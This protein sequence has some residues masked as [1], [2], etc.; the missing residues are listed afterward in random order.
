MAR[1]SIVKNYGHFK[2][3]FDII[4]NSIKISQDTKIYITHIKFNIR[5]VNEYLNDRIKKV[6]EQ[7]KIKGGEILYSTTNSRIKGDENKLISIFGDTIIKDCVYNRCENF[8]KLDKCI[9][10]L[11]C[12]LIENDNIRDNLLVKVKRIDKPKKPNMSSEDFFDILKS[13]E[14]YLEQRKKL[15]E[16][17]VNSNDD[18][19]QMFNYLLSSDSVKDDSAKADRKKLYK[20][21]NNEDFSED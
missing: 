13:L 14:G 19:V 20:F 5:D 9:E 6:N 8:E 21:L 4:L 3:I 10:Q 16:K 7:Q 12:K 18:F 17:A 11:Y 1:K 15:I 2:R